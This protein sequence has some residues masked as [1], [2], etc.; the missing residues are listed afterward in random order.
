MTG[1]RN[2]VKGILGLAIVLAAFVSAEAS[3]QQNMNVSATVPEVC[4]ISNEN[5]DLDMAFD[6]SSLASATTDFEVDVNFLWRCSQDNAATINISSGGGD[7][8]NGTTRYMTGPGGALLAYSISKPD[9]SAW[10]DGSNGQSGLG[11]TGQGM[12]NADEQ[13]T[14][15]TGTVTLSDAQAAPVGSY[16][17]TVQ[18]SLLP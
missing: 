10:G 11:V 3:A 1:A 12:A 14:V 8:A 5:T 2:N 13:T 6:L 18:I 15:V 9:N 4:V 17:D 16:S 7:G